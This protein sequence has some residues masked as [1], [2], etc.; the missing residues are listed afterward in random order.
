MD[1]VI[2]PALDELRG[3]GT[4]YT[5]LLYA[6][7]CLTA[8]GPRVIE[9]NARF[10]D[11]ETQAVLDRLATPLGGLLLAAALPATWPA[12]ARCAGPRARRWPS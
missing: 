10:G 9:F 6:G 5:G 4:P 7:L 11:P 3:R 1:Q 12:P 2:Q 8:S